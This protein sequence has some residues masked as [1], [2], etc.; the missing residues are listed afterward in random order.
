MNAAQ[1]GHCRKG[2]W[3]EL[4]G[5]IAKLPSEDFSRFSFDAVL[6]HQPALE[7][8]VAVAGADHVL[9]GAD[10]PFRLADPDPVGS[11]RA[12]SALDEATRQALLGK[13]ARG[14]LNLSRSTANER[15]P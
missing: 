14:Y 12:C 1:T 6:V 9:L 2:A 7:Y 11:V 3:P 4:Q 15:Y 10:Y 8:L 5:A 13:N